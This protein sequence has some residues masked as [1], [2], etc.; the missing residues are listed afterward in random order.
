MWGEQEGNSR[1]VQ[2]ASVSVSLQ[3]FFL[4][5][6]DLASKPMLM[7]TMD[8]SNVPLASHLT[9]EILEAA[10]KKVFINIFNNNQN[11]AAASLDWCR[12]QN[13]TQRKPSVPLR[14]SSWFL[15][16][17]A[18][19][20]AHLP[21]LTCCSLRNTLWPWQWHV[22]FRLSFHVDCGFC[23]VLCDARD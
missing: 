23:C 1:D 10:T 20:G 6:Y 16:V 11:A 3:L 12:I 21:S 9:L 15:P 18:G 13:S 7:C 5:V 8:F 19:A 2:T 4:V 17:E 22:C 14:R